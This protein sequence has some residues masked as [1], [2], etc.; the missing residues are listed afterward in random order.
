MQNVTQIIQL[1]LPALQKTGKPQLGIAF[2]C[3]GGRHRS[4]TS[5]EYLASWA[6]D[7]EIKH[8][9]EHLEL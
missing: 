6:K 5:A 4:V 7:R 2:G 8:V 1:I 9:L 3:T